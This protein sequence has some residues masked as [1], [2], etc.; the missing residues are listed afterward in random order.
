MSLSNALDA[1]EVRQTKAKAAFD[2]HAKLI[3]KAHDSGLVNRDVM[4][5]LFALHKEQ[6]LMIQQTELTLQAAMSLL[7]AVAKA[8]YASGSDFAKLR[9]QLTI[10]VRM[11]AKGQKAR[12]VR[13]EKE[14]YYLV[15]Q[16]LIK[17]WQSGKYQFRTN[18]VRFNCD[19]LG[20]QYS[21]GLKILQNIP[22][23]SGK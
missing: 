23:S 21:T 3:L 12:K 16:E 9:E 2:M 6:K 4:K 14:K 8:T 15:K 7:S 20:I 1:L 10:Q 22:K 17:I 5:S 19:K 13:A 18:C 11:S